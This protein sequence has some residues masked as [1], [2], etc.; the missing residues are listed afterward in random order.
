MKAIQRSTLLFSHLLLAATICLAETRNQEHRVAGGSTP[1]TAGVRGRTSTG[2]K[3]AALKVFSGGLLRFEA[4]AGQFDPQVRFASRGAAH[5]LFLT[6]GEAVFVL[7]RPEREK[8]EARWNPRQRFEN[9]PVDRTVARLRLVHANPASRIEGLDQLSSRSNY[10]LG[11]DPSAWR[12]GVEHFARVRYRNVYPG[13]DWVYYGTDGRLEYD[14][15]VTPGADP[16]QVMLDI[17]VEGSGGAEAV[18]VNEDGDLIMDSRAD[19]IRFLRPVAYQIVDGERQ[20]VTVNYT[21]KSP[22]RV[23][24]ELGHYDP[25]RELVIDPVLIFS[26]YLG[27]PSGN[28]AGF[29]VAV[30]STGIYVAGQ[31]DAGDFPATTGALREI[32]G[33]ASCSS[34]VNP[35]PCFDAFVSKLNLDGTLFYSTYLGG[36]ARDGAFGIAVDGS[37]RAIVTGGTHSANFPVTPSAFQANIAPGTCVAS[38]NSNITCEDAFVAVLND[39]GSAL[40][41]STYLGGAGGDFGNAVAVDLSG[42]AY[43]TG[44]TDSDLAS[45]PATFGSPGGGTCTDDGISSFPCGDAFVAKLNPNLVGPDSRVYAMFLGGNGDDFGNAIAVDTSTNVFVGGPTVENTSGGNSFPTPGGF[46]TAFG[47]FVDGF[48]AR[49]DMLGHQLLIRRCSVG[50]TTIKSWDCRRFDGLGASDR[51]HPF[52]KFPC[53]ECSRWTGRARPEQLQRLL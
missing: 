3:Q 6:P 30:D 48:L 50:T 14:F 52:R 47:G 46:Q 34:T 39:M 41:Y 22:G 10:L 2:A 45:F 43:V 5:R 7:S 1:T 17:A 25:A 33:V 42:N 23:G 49:I 38:D 36:S 31:T 26:T 11:K 32:P 35:N 21:M 16:A 20:L 4:N 53:Q 27:G 44:F 29:S 19:G 8:K 18:R 40:D 9:R 15:V 24:F 28:S 51:V 37:G 12:A 13:I